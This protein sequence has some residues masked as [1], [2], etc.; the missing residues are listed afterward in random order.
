MQLDVRPELIP[1]SYDGP[2]N[3]GINM[4]GELPHRTNFKRTRSRAEI[5]AIYFSKDIVF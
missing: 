3:Q 4:N 1:Q 5:S 2:K